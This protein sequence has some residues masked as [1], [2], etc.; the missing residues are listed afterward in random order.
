MA[1]YNNLYRTQQEP[2]STYEEQLCQLLRIT[3]DGDLV[4]KSHRDRLVKDG[5][6]E[7]AAGYNI[8]TP[9][10]IRHLDNSKLIQP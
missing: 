2:F 3:W 9:A 7:K 4:S 10:G 1:D 6:A 8:I 5:F